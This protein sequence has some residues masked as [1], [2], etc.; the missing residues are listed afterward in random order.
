MCMYCLYLVCVC[1]FKEG[2]LLEKAGRHKGVSEA[3][4]K[5]AEQQPR[6]ADVDRVRSRTHK[7]HRHLQEEWDF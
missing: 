1:T 6:G 3:E 5:A 2:E 4:E 7:T